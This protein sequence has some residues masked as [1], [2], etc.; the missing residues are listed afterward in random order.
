MSYWV[1]DR[2]I[3]EAKIQRLEKQ[4]AQMT[5]E[6]DEA[7]R[8]SQFWKDNHLAGNAQIDALRAEVERLQKAEVDFHMDYRMKCDVETKALHV[9]VERL[10]ALVAQARDEEAE[11]CALIVEDYVRMVDAQSALAA[12]RARIAARKGGGNDGS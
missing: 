11:A 7:R 3:T 2:Y 8:T 1:Y 4:L 5:R 6:R 10:Q 9:E 12:I